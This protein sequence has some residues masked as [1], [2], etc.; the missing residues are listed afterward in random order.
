MSSHIRL[1]VFSTYL[2]VLSVSALA[3]VSISARQHP[4]NLQHR[5]RA[6]AGLSAWGSTVTLGF[7]G[8]AAREHQTA[9]V[10][11]RVAVFFSGQQR[12]RHAHHAV[13]VP[14]FGHR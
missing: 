13:E 3:V 11:S 6:R 10:T 1:L 5:Q 2:C 14:A 9:Y 4:T 8:R 12:N 7:H